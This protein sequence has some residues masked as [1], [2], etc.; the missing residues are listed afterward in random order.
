MGADSLSEKDDFEH[1]D[2]RPYQAT[3]N[4][5][6][7]IMG[8]DPETSAVNSYLQMWDTENLFVVGGSVY[9]HHSG[10]NATGTLCALAY[11]APEGMIDYLEGDRGL[12]VRPTEKTTNSSEL[13]CLLNEFTFIKQTFFN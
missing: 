6:G 9:P 10:Y 4:T 12:L 3:H 7:T 2:N 5:G 11:R 8:E 13:T 1:Y